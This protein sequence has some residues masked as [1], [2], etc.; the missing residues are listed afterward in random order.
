QLKL[1]R[2]I[3]PLGNRLSR[4]QAEL[5]EFVPG[6]PFSRDNYRSLQ[7]DSICPE[8]NNTLATVFDIQPTALEEIVPAYLLKKKNK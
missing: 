7:L 8:S 4:Y 1:K 6:K 5:M 3:V 2:M